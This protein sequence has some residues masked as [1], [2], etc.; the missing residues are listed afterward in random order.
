MWFAQLFLNV[1]PNLKVIRSFIHSTVN[2][3]KKKILV[4]LSFALAK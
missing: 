2:Y 1:L 4:S 3:N